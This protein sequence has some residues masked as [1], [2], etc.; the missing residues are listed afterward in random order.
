MG[1]RNRQPLAKGRGVHRE[2]E[3]E[4]S[5]QQ[6]SAPMNTNHIRHIRWDEG[7]L[8]YL[9]TGDLTDVQKKSMKIREPPYPPTGGRTVV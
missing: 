2:M 9:T 5:L 1:V 3:S 6:S 4:G 8:P 7:Y